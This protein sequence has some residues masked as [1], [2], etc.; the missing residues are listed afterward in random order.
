MTSSADD[1]LV[2]GP[3]AVLIRSDWT[4]EL[5]RVPADQR[6]AFAT[7]PQ[8]IETM[9]NSLLV[10]RTLAQRARERGMEKDPIVQ[11]RLMIEMERGLA[12]MMVERIETDAGAEFDRATEKNLA[13]ARE[14]Y[15]INRTKY[16]VPEEI[17]VSHILFDVTKRGKDA[18]LAAANDARAKLLA[19]A[20]ITELAPKLS[21]DTS[22]TRN[23]GRLDSGP[24]GRFDPTFEAAAFALKNPGDVSEPVLTRFGYHVIK[25]EGR[26][27]SRQMSFDEVQ[28]KIL[29]EMRLK[30]I[31][32]ARESVVAAI[33]R[34]PR[35]TVNQAVV[36]GLIAKVDIGAPPVNA[37]PPAP[38][39]SPK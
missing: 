20:D 8:R 4:A 28:S 24:R 13:R 16:V 22:V 26:Q 18:A 29:A 36:E 2:T 12:A 19:G 11:R 21:D 9:L 37:A 32:D 17:D 3:E 6:L 14:L 34:D 35:V 30:Y 7:S 1:V 5:T 27:P 39:S 25:L 23:K 31:E 33:R 10:N 15:L 38:G